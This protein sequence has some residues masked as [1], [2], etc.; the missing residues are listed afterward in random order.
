MLPVYLM[1]L[2]AAAC[3][4]LGLRGLQLARADEQVAVSAMPPSPKRK[5]DLSV[6]VR[7]ADR[8]GAPLARPTQELL[9]PQKTKILRRIEQAGRPGGMTYESYCRQSAGFLV[10]FGVPG[11]FLMLQGEMLYG[12]ACLL[13]ALQHEGVIRARMRKRQDQIQR[14]MPDFL[15]VLAVTVAA[16]LSFRHA[17][18]RVAESMPGALADEFT[19]ALRQMD[20]GTP[21]RQAFE[22]LRKRNDSEAVGQFVTAILQA[23]ELGAPLSSALND[24][25]LDMRRESA[26]WSK[27]KAQ[28]IS[29]Q[30]TAVTAFLVLPAL[31]AVM[32]GA[33]FIGANGGG[34]GDLGNP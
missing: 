16:G 28:K 31:L 21:R 23:E 11:V 24:I 1:G 15:D 32:A 7:I 18:E 8:L 14:S 34:L 2:G 5:N 3:V 33:M 9:A 17:L 19:V 26:Q 30:I 25:A 29:P 20:L 13:G 22:D 4:L 6:F 10:L 12:A 27:Q